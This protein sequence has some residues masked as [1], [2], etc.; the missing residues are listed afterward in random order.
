MNVTDPIW[1]VA[2][3]SPGR[4]AVVF[5]GQAVSFGELT[6]NI[7]RTMANAASRGIVAGRHVLVATDN[8]LMHLALLLALARLGAVSVAAAAAANQELRAALA[9]Q[10]GVTAFVRSNPQWV[11]P[12]IPENDHFLAEDLVRPGT[13]AVAPAQPAT[14]AGEKPWRIFL[15]SGTTGTPKGV[16]WTHANTARY[17]QLLQTIFPSGQ[18]ER[19]LMMIGPDTHFASNNT[20]RQL[21]AGGAVVLP[22][23]TDAAEIF[24]CIARDRVTQLFASP[25]TAWSFVQ[26]AK[27]ADPAETLPARELRR[28]AVGG[29]HMSEELRAEVRSLVCANLYINYGSTEA[30]LMASA[31]PETLQNF[32]GTSGRIVPWAEM[33]TVDDHGTVLPPGSR[34]NLRIRV[35]ASA[36]GYVGDPEASAKTFRDG[37]YYPGDTGVV[38]S[39]GV[40]TLGSRA[41]DII[42]ISGTKIDP[43]VIEAVL[44]EDPAIRESMV[45][46]AKTDVGV[47]VVAA[48]IVVNH[49]P[50]TD[51]LRARCQERFGAHLSPAVFFTTDQLPRNENGKLRR[52]EVADKL[53]LQSAPA[54]KA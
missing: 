18:G 11:N 19:L 4:T 25:A 36:S 45:V 42:N 30:G 24:K 23:S 10:F 48:L 32:P 53:L 2:A 52:R 40:L 28:F 41:D 21:C 33:Q 5:N 31:D 49:P 26:H 22:G 3:M 38:D 29:A 34:G 39:Q 20:L 35:P 17:L 47:P 16:A 44:N 51:A 37:W 54:K 13:G 46:A 27:K 7:D 9:R 1:R 43:A 6:A 8:P 50:D 14:D 15:S 12:A